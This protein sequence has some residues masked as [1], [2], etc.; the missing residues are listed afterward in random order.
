[1]NA[2]DGRKKIVENLNYE[3]NVLNAFD[4][5]AISILHYLLTWQFSIFF[6]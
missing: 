5:L 3:K 1:M 4:I 2:W 6:F